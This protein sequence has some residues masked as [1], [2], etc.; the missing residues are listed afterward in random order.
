MKFRSR[1]TG[2]PSRA[3]SILTYFVSI[4]LTVD[5]SGGRG[6]AADAALLA[7]ERS[8]SVFGGGACTG[9]VARRWEF[10]VLFRGSGGGGECL[11]GDIVA[12]EERG[13]LAFTVDSC[14]EDV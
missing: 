1:H 12:S 11:M 4:W 2:I 5:G 7:E 10:M 14:L 9:G 6:A 13:G 8:G 3:N